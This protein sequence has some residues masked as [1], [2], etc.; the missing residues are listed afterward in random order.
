MTSSSAT[1]SD[2][3]AYGRLATIVSGVVALLVLECTIQALFF[4]SVGKA[5]WWQSLFRAQCGLFVGFPVLLLTGTVAGIAQPAKS[6]IVFSGVVLWATLCFV[7]IRAFLLWIRS[8][9]PERCS[10]R[11]LRCP[12]ERCGYS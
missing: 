8:A 6:I 3:T 1:R 7:V 4:P 5:D 12:F 10:E 9:E 11:P 2:G